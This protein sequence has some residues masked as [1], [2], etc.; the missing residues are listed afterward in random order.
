MKTQKS[1]LKVLCALLIVTVAA[2]GLYNFSLSTIVP[3]ALISIAF[4][5]PAML[6]NTG[7]SSKELR[8][9]R[10]LVKDQIAV[11]EG[12]ATADNN[13][14]YTEDEQKELRA[15][16]DEENRFTDAI[17]LALSLEKRS[18]LLVVDSVHKT[19]EQ[20]EIEKFS[21][22]KMIKE[23]R[24]GGANGISGLEKELIDESEK[25]G[26]ALGAVEQG[27][28]YLS[29]NLMSSLVNKRTTNGQSAGTAAAGGNLIP[30]EKVGFFDALWAL[31]VLDKLGVQKMTGLSANTDLNGWDAAPVAY[32]AAENGTQSITDATIANRTLRP[33]LLGSAVD[34]SMLLRIQTNASVDAYF[35]DGM[36][37]AMAVAFENAVINGDGSNKPTGI[38]G[39]SGIQ[40]VATGTNGGAPTYA[41]VLALITKVL[42]ANASEAN[43]KFLTN[44][45]VRGKLKNIPIDAGSGAMI[46]SYM[47]YFQGEANMI[48]G[49]ETFCTSNVPSTLTKGSSGAV[50]SPLIFGDFSQVTTAQFGGVLLSVDE[51]SAAMRRSGK[52]ALTINMYVDSAVKQPAAL[53]AILDLTTT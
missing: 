24:T 26:R 27:K 50:C 25:E 13:R 34:I 53:G 1:I 4:V 5:L 33:K 11:I 8:E 2:I 3:D 44:F 48:D 45:K 38:L 21:L 10:K 6:T 47:K 52:Y 41:N 12:R 42:Q 18:S 19:P 51:V 17:E 22:G 37:K 29:N 32:W 39:T 7:K 36:M 15:L 28:I 43:C 30:T 16:I 40:D 31:M 14:Q 49:F 23:I 9:A 46:M 35:L 20:R